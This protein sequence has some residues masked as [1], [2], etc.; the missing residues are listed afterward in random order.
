MHGLLVFIAKKRIQL[1]MRNFATR[2]W[3]SVY[4]SFPIFRIFQSATTK[5]FLDVVP[6]NSNM[7]FVWICVILHIPLQC[8]SHKCISRVFENISRYTSGKLEDKNH[9][10]KA[11]ELKKI[12]LKIIYQNWNVTY[13]N[14]QAIILFHSS[15]VGNIILKPYFSI[16]NYLIYPKHPKNAMK[17]MIAPMTIKNVGSVKN[18]ASR[19]SS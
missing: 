12:F 2:K 16:E 9:T 8:R 13:S 10:E 7:G 11:A 1:S 4:G 15:K 5:G 17:K 19:N 14:N 3:N 6:A 18:C